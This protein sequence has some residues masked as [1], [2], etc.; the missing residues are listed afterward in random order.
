MATNLEV[1]TFEYLIGLIGRFQV[2]ANVFRLLA[3]GVDR[4]Q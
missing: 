4:Q 2:S 1:D 3:A